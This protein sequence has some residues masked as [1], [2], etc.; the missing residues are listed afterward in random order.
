[1][2][3]EIFWSAISWTI[4]W[5]QN[6]EHK[7]VKPTWP[8]DQIEKAGLLVD[9]KSLIMNLQKVVCISHMAV[10]APVHK[11]MLGEGGGGEGLFISSNFSPHSHPIPFSHPSTFLFLPPFKPLSAI[12]PFIIPVVHYLVLI[13]LFAVIFYKHKENIWTWF[14]LFKLFGCFKFRQNRPEMFKR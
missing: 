14:P 1:M 6:N 12:V 11:Y 13:R 4:F 8:K 5:N 7:N 10:Q 3:W 9:D 2:T